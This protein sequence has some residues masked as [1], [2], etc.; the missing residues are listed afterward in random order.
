[1][2]VLGAG[3]LSCPTCKSSLQAE[4]LEITDKPSGSQLLDTDSSLSSPSSGHGCD[5]AV[6]MGV[7][8]SSKLQTLL[9]DLAKVREESST[10][11]V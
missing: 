3:T 5:E 9:A 10:A 7:H 2:S 8:M 11:K 6:A 1:M 4:Q